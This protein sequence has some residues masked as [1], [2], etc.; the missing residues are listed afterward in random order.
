MGSSIGS[1]GD[2]KRTG[3]RGADLLVEAGR[4]LET[5]QMPWNR[6]TRGVIG[7]VT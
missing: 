4:G 3:E 5:R 7:D 1:M 6:G 2:L